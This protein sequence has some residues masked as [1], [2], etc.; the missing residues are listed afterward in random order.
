[1]YIYRQKHTAVDV[2]DLQCQSTSGHFYPPRWHGRAEGAN[3]PTTE[4]K[5][6]SCYPLTIIIGLINS[7]YLNYLCINSD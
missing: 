3:F 6:T 4:R 7:D 2:E 1:M 5:V